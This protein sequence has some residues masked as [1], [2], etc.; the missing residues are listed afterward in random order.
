MQ[1]FATA[2]ALSQSELRTCVAE[3]SPGVA[4]T[5]DLDEFRNRR[6][7]ILGAFECA[8]GLK[9]FSDW[10]QQSESFSNSRSEKLD[11]YLKLAYTVLQDIL[12]CSQGRNAIKHRDVQQRI[13]AIANAV[14][15]PWLE[16]ATRHIDELVMMARRN[17]QK[18]AA[19][20]AMIINLRNP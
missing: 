16:R 1:A 17:I 6:A 13:S 8:A 12:R 14:S 3:G 20:D 2:K 18:T 5:I 10:V 9:P 7:L 15:F 11:V 19:L 4:A